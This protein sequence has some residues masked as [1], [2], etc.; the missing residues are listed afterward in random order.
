MAAEDKF[1]FQAVTSA[2][3]HNGGGITITRI[4]HKAAGFKAYAYQCSLE[5][6]LDGAPEAYG[7][8]NPDPVDPE[9][10][11]ATDQQHDIEMLESSISNAADPYPNCDYALTHKSVPASQR[12]VFQW[13]GM[14]ATTPTEARRDG[15][16][17]DQRG[18]L[19]ARGWRDD[20]DVLHALAAGKEGKYPVIQPFQGRYGGSNSIIGAPGYY[21]STTSGKIN[22]D[23]DPWDQLRYI[24]ATDIPYAAWAKWWHHYGVD[25][26]DF[27]LAL[28]Y[29]SAAHSGFVFG[30]SGSGKV[31]EISRKLFETLAPGRDNEPREF[32]FLVYRG[33]RVHT[34]VSPPTNPA[35]QEKAKFWTTRLSAIYGN[36]V[37]PLFLSCGADMDRFN[38]Y[39]A[40]KL[41]AA[42]QTIA[43]QRYQRT[44]AVMQRYGFI[45]SGMDPPKKGD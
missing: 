26:G 27:G 15:L 35:V 41:S 2:E 14:Y 20:H 7:L 37:V 11:P 39:R 31:G 32:T 18:F 21:V 40:K 25:L 6:D 29:N 38:R 42:E 16:S 22:P 12:P 10:N 36:E 44:L 8:N 30:D 4:E 5:E 43:D 19:E 9:H 17:I 1:T 33:S 13:V 24:D 3:D 23:L 28:R 45:P 34:A